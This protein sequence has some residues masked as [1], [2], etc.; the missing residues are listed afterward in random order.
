MTIRIDHMAKLD[1]TTVRN[2]F[3][4]IDGET[5]ILPENAFN[6]CKWDDQEV[7][8]ATGNEGATM[9]R[10]YTTVQIT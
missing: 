7:E 1:G 2:P 8:E 6:N 5:E 10:W 4:I 9:E 3:T